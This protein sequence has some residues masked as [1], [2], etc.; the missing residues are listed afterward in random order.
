[1]ADGVYVKVPKNL[2]DDLDRD[3]FRIAGT[4]RGIETV[5]ADSAN[6][7][8]VL[9]GSHEISRFVGH[10]WAAAR[11]HGNSPGSGVKLIVERDGRR[12]ELTLEHEGFG[13]EG[14]PEKVVRGMTALL[15]TLSDRDT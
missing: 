10:L 15:K 1:M 14:P 3:G 13:D 5:L 2:A 11:R 4:E 9:V 8:T 6:L 7:V 12:V